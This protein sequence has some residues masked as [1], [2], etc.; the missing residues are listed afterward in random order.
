MLLIGTNLCQPTMSVLLDLILNFALYTM[1]EYELKRAKLKLHWERQYLLEGVGKGAKNAFLSTFNQLDVDFKHSIQALDLKAPKVLDIGTGSGEQAFEMAK[2]GLRV[3]AIDISK[4]I[5]DQTIENFGSE[6][7]HLRF[8]TMDFLEM[9]LEP[10][11]DMVFDRGCF[12]LL[13]ASLK[14]AY[15]G[16]LK[17]ALK[18][19]GMFCLKTDF[20][21]GQEIFQKA[22]NEQFVTEELRESI[23]EAPVPQNIR[24]AYYSTWRKK[25]S[26][27]K[28]SKI[29]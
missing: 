11:Y 28:E 23:Y 13:P 27:A 29:T 10:S 17:R 26:Q 25:C 19:N 8:L 4:T 12:T 24:K 3:T 20:A 14:P 5:I 22:L 6:I 9:P 21:K 7:L 2:M 16:Q 15:V 1:N 18:T